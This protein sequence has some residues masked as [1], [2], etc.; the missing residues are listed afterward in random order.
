LGKLLLRRGLFLRAEEHLTRAIQRLTV[1]NPNP[2]TGE[3]HYYLGLSF[4]FQ[5]RIADAFAAFY[6]A[7]WNYEWRSAAYYRLACLDA[8]RGQW[9]HALDHIDRSLAT[10]RD[11]LHARGLQSA[12]LRKIGRTGEALAVASDA[13]SN[14]PLDFL[15]RFELLLLEGL[16]SENAAQRL[17]Q[18]TNMDRQLHLDVASDYAA[19][20]LLAEARALLLCVASDPLSSTYPMVYYFLAHLAEQTGDLDL[21]V[22]YRTLAA[23][24]SPDYCFPSRLEEMIALEDALDR[25][26]LDAKGAYYLGNLY[27]DKKRYEDAISLW[28][29]SVALDAGFSIPWRN[30]GIAYFNIHH[31]AERALDAYERA[32]L[33]NPGDARLVYEL[34]QLRKRTGVPPI[35]RLAFLEKRS[36]LIAQRDDLT[37]ELITLYNQI[38][39]PGKA[40]EI[41]R[42]RRFHPWEGGEGLVSGQYAWAH[43]LLGISCLNHRDYAGAMEHFR[44]ARTYPHNLGEGKHLLTQELDLDYFCGVALREL[45]RDEMARNSFRSAAESE[46]ASPWMCYY[47]TMALRSLGMTSAAVEVIQEMTQRLDARRKSEP[48]IDYFATSLPNFLVFEDDL[49]LRKEIEC[50]FTEALVELALGNELSAGRKLQL[51]VDMDPNNLAA[52]TMLTQLGRTGE[53]V[54]ESASWLAK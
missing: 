50:A 27:Y 29:K 12:I 16:T 45:G 46:P 15:S 42:L 30:L 13:V 6:K 14:D 43:R 8:R 40:L 11:H 2:A 48:S 26:P 25:N 39:Q 21:A 4:L 3:A 34:D 37:V 53:T 35:E 5:G 28:E 7:T 36:D 22:E 52:Q 47:K 49:A 10:N 20:G 38:G 41:L 17:A 24:A 18:Q 32:L 44:S 23:S 19:A 51:V 33:A 1:R 54:I 31:S 9:S